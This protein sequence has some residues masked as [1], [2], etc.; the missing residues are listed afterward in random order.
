MKRLLILV[1]LPL[2]L[3]ACGDSSGTATQNGVS[4]SAGKP[5]SEAEQRD[6][7]AE[8]HEIF[9][10]YFEIQLERSPIFASSIGDDRY[11]DR[12]TV[13]IDPEFM[14]EGLE[15]DREYLARVQTIDESLLE[16]QDL[17]SYQVFIRD[18]ERDIEG[19]E[20]P[21][22]LI[23]LNQFYS[24]PN[25]FAQLGS[26]GSVHP[27][28]SVKDYEDFLSRVDG[29]VQWIDQA[30]ANM[31]EGI[32][33]GVVQPR[34]LMERSVPQLEA[35]IVEDVE[36]SLFWKPV[37]NIPESFPAEDRERLEA[38]Y[39]K[40]I[41]ERIVPA[42]AKLR[43]YVVETYMPQARDTHGMWD[44]PNGAAWY[45]WLVEGTTTTELT[46]AEIHQ[47]GLDEVERIHSEMHGVMEQ[48]G[49]EGTLDEFF[50]FM[51]NDPQFIAASREDLLQHYEDLREVIEPE[52]P[53]LFDVMPKAAFEIRAVEP[54]REKS[55]SGASYRRGTADGSRPGVF[56][57][58]TYDLSARPIWAVESL[59]LHEAAPG[60]HFQ[61]SIQQELDDLP[62]FRRYGGYTA[63]IEGWGLYAETLGEELGVYADPYQYF[64]KLNAELWRAI[65]LVVDSGLHYKGW[66]R[67]EV[68]DF[69]YE[70][71]AVKEARAVSEAE[72]YMAIPS[73]ALAY[74][75]GQLKISALREKAEQALG[76]D[77]S[78]REYHNQVLLDG[79]LPLS[80]LEEKI[81][82]WIASKQ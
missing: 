60:H 37:D 10:E 12:F 65:R 35:H 18:L 58:N 46:P 25:F 79:A 24:T 40:T 75:I 2:A 14:A 30:I 53:K 70:N 55:A 57:V 7:A 50:E 41:S 32:E 48:V 72:R 39:R 26:G 51:S 28:D 80:V 42:Y 21:S 34:L 82:R 36:V 11:N 63:F 56:Y 23:P 67:D 19:A 9:D 38:A 5:A 4:Q 54:F 61:I 13:S 59:Y 17:L 20:F 31:N 16:G 1:L 27:F 3:L 45:A 73:Q 43:D 49:F 15:I 64:G 8:L 69:M 81:D 52:L 47:V 22:H 33:K 68:L 78:I 74:K 62:A 71:S 77:F 76:D 6:A 66:S 44:L 29:F